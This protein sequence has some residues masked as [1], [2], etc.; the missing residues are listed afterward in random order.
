[1]REW[2]Q[3]K[4]EK[5][6]FISSKFLNVP[7]GRIKL[8]FKSKKE[9]FVIQLKSV[10][11]MTYVEY[12]E[13]LAK[14]KN[15]NEFVKNLKNFR[16]QG[17]VI[18]YEKRNHFFTDWIQFNGYKDIGKEIG[19]DKAILV[20]K[21]L[22]FDKDKGIILKTVPVK[23]RAFYYIPSKKIDNSIKEK[24]KTGDIIG[25]FAYD[26]DWLDVTHIGYIIRKNNKLYFRNAS[27]LKKYKKVV[28][29]PLKDYLKRVKGIVILRK[30]K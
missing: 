16:Y 29:I 24:L 30:E 4:E 1:M 8:G 14:S 9:Y 22:N 11:C 15:F 21:H 20:K 5:I 25:A 27:S 26:K 6:D 23:N 10:D 3:T 18:K 17:G 28:D 2:L 19:K 12:V 7:Y 13:N